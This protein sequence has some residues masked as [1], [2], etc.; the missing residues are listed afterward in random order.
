[1]LVAPGAG[2]RDGLEQLVDAVGLGHVGVGADAEAVHPVLD[3]VERREHDDGDEHRRP[4]GPQPPADVEAVD[5]RQHQVEQHDVGHVLPGQPQPGLAVL[6]DR[7]ARIRAVRRIR[8]T[9]PACSGW[10]STIR[11]VAIIVFPAG[12]VAA[13]VSVRPSSRPGR[14]WTPCE[15]ESSIRL[16]GFRRHGACSSTMSASCSSW[17]RFTV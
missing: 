4:V 17:S 1:M 12:P 3:V 10:S 15:T 7:S 9:S 5:V 16:T 6:G 11:A 8:A 14:A 2:G 13:R